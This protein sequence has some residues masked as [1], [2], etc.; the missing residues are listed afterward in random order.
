MNNF[1][2]SIIVVIALSVAGCATISENVD[3]LRV[4]IV[5]GTLKVIERDNDISASDVQDAVTR[6]ESVI[7]NNSIITSNIK[8][9]ALK[10]INFN[11]LSAADQFL[12]SE[13]LTN[14]EMTIEREIELGNLVQEDVRIRIQEFVDYIEYAAILSTSN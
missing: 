5:Y 1:M 14:V 10:A 7:N 2:K 12:V 3:S 11:S 13:V 4:P 6:V 8:E 9:E